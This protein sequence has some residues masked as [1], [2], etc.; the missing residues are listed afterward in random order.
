MFCE[1]YTSVSFLV[2]SAE[3]PQLLYYSHL[4]AVIVSLIVSFFVFLHNKQSLSAKLLIV[5]SSLFAFWS[6]VDLFLWTQTHSGILMFL[7]SFWFLV[8][9]SIFAFSFYF[10]Y[11]FIYK[12]DLPFYGKSLLIVSLLPLVVSF[13]TP[14]N[15]G[16][17]DVIA[18]NAIENP[19]SIAYSYGLSALYFILI[20]ILSMRGSKT[21]ID[22]ERK[23]NFFACMGVIFFLLSFSAATYIASLSNLFSSSPNTFAIE[24][25][26][27][28]G[29]TI[30]IAF[31]TY[32]VVQYKAF[33][34][35]LLAAQALVVSLVVLIGS[36]FFFIRNNTN[37]VLNLITFVV[38]IVFG[39]LL[40]K[41]VKKVEEQ[42]EQLAIANQN[43]TELLR[44]ITHQVKGFFT[45]TKM[46]FAGLVDG[47]YGKVSE[48][49]LGVAK[50]GLT[51]DNTAV[52]M[53]QNILH[54]SNLRLGKMKFEF[55]KINISEILE[56]EVK[57]SEMLFK[58]K[59]L[60]KEI[61]IDKDV[62]VSADPKQ[63][64]HIF[65]NLINNALLYTQ[66]G[67]I[68]I[69]L[70]KQGN[71]AI[72]SITDTGIGLSPLD[73]QKLFKE[74]GMG[75]RSLGLNP[76]STGFGLYI[77]K[78]IVEQHGGKI[79]AESDGENKGSTFNVK[80]PLIR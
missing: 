19:I 34:V 49:V 20:V 31:L 77:A 67:K 48:G 36:Q 33:N 70:K 66:K 74:S 8:F 27:Y 11:S 71:E 75:D 2:F 32:T 5:V 53:I 69:L 14:Y 21:S 51:F 63:I 43:Q 45:K 62:F 61:S 52:D 17:F 79:W 3:A 23:Q 13:A 35:K 41:S 64:S 26:G 1:P 59:G 57:N 12:K 54:A 4:P 24:Q 29:M 68:S 6:I 15:L 28:F 80:L 76:N 55:Q 9:S 42:R 50:Q 25:Y 44:F 30:F 46:I 56:E 38:A 37:K 10:L 7:W 16:I 65:K 39:W 73:K 60:D 72:I 78:R 40:V 18:C 47:S 58:E 22:V